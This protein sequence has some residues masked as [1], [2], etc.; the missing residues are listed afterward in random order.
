MHVACLSRRMP[1]FFRDY[2]YGRVV[3]SRGSKGHRLAGRLAGRGSPVIAD[4]LSDDEGVLAKSKTGQSSIELDIDDIGFSSL[5]PI[6]EFW[7]SEHLELGPLQEFSAICGY[8]QVN[9]FETPTA[10]SRRQSCVLTVGI[11]SRQRGRLA[12]TDHDHC[13]RGL[14]Q[15]VVRTVTASTATAPYSKAHMKDVGNGS[16][17]A[18]A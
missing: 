3:Q 4:R 13:G 16:P 6:S 11:L 5:L 10:L 7:N 1:R 12:E 14:I 15:N 2:P 18:S 9:L 17:A 8:S